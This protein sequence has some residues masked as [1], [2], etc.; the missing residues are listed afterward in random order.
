MT[1]VIAAVRAGDVAT[2]ERL[3]GGDPALAA[4]TEEG[5]SAVRIAI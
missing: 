5:V 4:S 1:D 3:V 2:I